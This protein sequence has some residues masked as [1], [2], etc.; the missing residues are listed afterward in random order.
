M[1]KHLPSCLPCNLNDDPDADHPPTAAALSAA[2]FAAVLGCTVYQFP[3]FTDAYETTYQW[4][5]PT[6]WMWYKQGHWPCAFY[7][8]HGITDI[9]LAKRS[10]YQKVLIVY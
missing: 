6:I 4:T 1:F 7:W 2:W 3:S 5:L 9:E 10:G 8:S